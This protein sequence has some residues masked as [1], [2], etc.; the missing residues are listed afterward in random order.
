MTQYIAEANKII[1]TSW[2][3]LIND[4]HL[5][6]VLPESLSIVFRKAPTNKDKL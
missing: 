3:I 6:E 2:E 1:K 4:L 5:R